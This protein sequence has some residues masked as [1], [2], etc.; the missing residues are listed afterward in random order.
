MK[1]VLN[2]LLGLA[3]AVIILG[4]CM[5][6]DIAGDLKDTELAAAMAV[7]KTEEGLA[8]QAELLH[9]DKA[10]ERQYADSYYRVAAEGVSLAEAQGNLYSRG[11]RQINFA[12]AG[13]LLLGSAAADLENWLDFAVVDDG[14]RPTVYPVLVEGSA[15]DFLQSGGDLSAAYLLESALEPWSGMSG[16]DAVTLQEFCLWL[17][18]PGIAAAL[19]IVRCADE[20]DGAGVVGIEPLGLAIYD[21]S[22]WR[23]ASGRDAL[24]WR[25]LLRGKHIRGEVV[26][27]GQGVSVKLLSARIKSEVEGLAVRFDIKIRAELADNPNGLSIQKVEER[28]SAFVVELLE[29]AVAEQRESGVDLLGLGREIWRNEPTLWAEIGASNYLAE[30]SAEFAVETEVESGAI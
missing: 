3:L 20:V 30:V 16:A 21:G 5:P 6:D 10:L 26:D 8:V 22:G 19:P 23:N 4:G 18:Q 25:I 12:H 14:L 1:T 13:L 15:A 11:A 9:R 2:A 7:D 24:A 29:G 28:L 17:K 27:L